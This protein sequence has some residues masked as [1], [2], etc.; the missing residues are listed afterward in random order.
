MNIVDLLRAQA[1][2]VNAEELQSRRDYHAYLRQQGDEQDTLEEHIAKYASLAR[3]GEPAGDEDIARLQALSQPKLPAPLQ[4]F[5]R[6][7]G[8]FLGGTHLQDLAIPAPAELL[9]AAARAPGD[10]EALASLGLADVVRWSWGNDR[11][12]FEPARRGGLKRD[13]VAALNRR[14]SAV[15]W[16]VVEDGE[17]FEYLYFDAEGRFGRLFYH[18]DA[19]DELYEHDLLPMLAES[20]AREGFDEA[21]AQLLAAATGPSFPD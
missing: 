17:G 21:F 7:A 13:E 18:Q 12:E 1:E 9:R 2:R 11:F 6:T 3:F 15:G 14:Y 8:S 16:R 20:P 5:Y 19:F 4:A 10:W